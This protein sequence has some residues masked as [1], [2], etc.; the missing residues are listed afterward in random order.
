MTRNQAVEE[1]R[2]LRTLIQKEC[3]GTLI[4]KL[5]LLRKLDELARQ[6]QHEFE[7]DPD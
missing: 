7:Q 4:D 6:L 1:I 5:D 3:C 2:N